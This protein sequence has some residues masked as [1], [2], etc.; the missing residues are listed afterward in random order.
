MPLLIFEDEHVARLHPVSLSRPAYAISV[1]SYRLI[2][3]LLT[4]NEGIATVTAMGWCW[5]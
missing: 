1:G 3:R 4:W 5:P 2:D